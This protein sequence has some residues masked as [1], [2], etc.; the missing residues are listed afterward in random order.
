METVPRSLWQE[1]KSVRA[2]QRLT[3][4]RKKHVLFQQTR[5]YFFTSNAGGEDQVSA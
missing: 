5:K 1:A 2:W 4:T 3:G